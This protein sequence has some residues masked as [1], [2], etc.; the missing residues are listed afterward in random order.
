[1]LLLAEDELRAP[2][3]HIENQQPLPGQLRGPGVVNALQARTVVST[4]EVELTITA[5]VGPQSPPTKL[6]A[7]IG[8]S[9]PGPA[10]ITFKQ[11]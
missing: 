10:S 4:T 3:A 2:A 8:G 5:R 11:W 6:T 1:M 9:A 7:V